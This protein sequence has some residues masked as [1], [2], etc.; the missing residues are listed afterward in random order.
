MSAPENLPTAAEQEE[1][2]QREWSDYLLAM[3]RWRQRGSVGPR[4]P[5]PVAPHTPGWPCPPHEEARDG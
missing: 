3:D 5:R 1:R 4:P 2:F